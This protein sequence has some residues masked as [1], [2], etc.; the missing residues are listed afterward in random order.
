M[1]SKYVER[2]IGPGRRNLINEIARLRGKLR[3]IYNLGTTGEDA[4]EMREIAGDALRIP[5]M[6]RK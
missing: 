2:V 6:A 5:P 3:A 4:I 1:V